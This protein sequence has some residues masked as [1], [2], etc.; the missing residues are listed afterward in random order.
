MD[1]SISNAKY[2]IL[3]LVCGTLLVTVIALSV[4]VPIGLTI[5]IY[6]SEY[7]S[8]RTKKII[9]PLL[10]ILAAIP[11]VVYGFLHFSSHSLSTRIY[12]IIRSFF[13]AL[14]LQV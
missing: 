12:T 10:E 4:A 14:S 1:S 3:P 5:A 7:A 2:G 11:T 6:L 8:I 13:N 9:K